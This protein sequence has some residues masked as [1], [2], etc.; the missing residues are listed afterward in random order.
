M[1]L[2]GAMREVQPES[3]GTGVN[4]RANDGRIA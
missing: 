3:I 2:E 1:L 4:Q